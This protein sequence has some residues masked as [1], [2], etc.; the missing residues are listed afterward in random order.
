[1]IEVKDLL[2]KFEGIIASKEA[3]VVAVQ[4]SIK[5]V[6]GLELKKTD[7]F[8]K[9]GDVYL[10][11][12]PIYR[13]EIFLNREGIIEKIESILGEKSPKNLR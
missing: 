9:G 4:K 6:C 10:S 11:T 13:N 1:M 3:G 5:D 7:I 2:S 12:K 8:I